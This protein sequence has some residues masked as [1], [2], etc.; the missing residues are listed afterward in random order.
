[1][2]VDVDEP[3]P[4]VH[5]PFLSPLLAEV[6]RILKPGGR[7]VMSNPVPRPRFANVFWRSGWAAIR[8]LLSAFPLLKYAD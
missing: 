2:V 3:S 7:L 8:Y 6:I 1:M 5:K 4:A